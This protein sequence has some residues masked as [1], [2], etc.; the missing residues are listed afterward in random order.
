MMLLSLFWI[1]FLAGSFVPLGSEVFLLALQKDGQ[2]IGWLLFISTL[3]NTLGGMSCY[4]IA[5]FG[6]RPLIHK[7]LRIQANK[8]DRWEGRLSGKGEWIALLCW[9]P[10]VGEVFAAILGLLSKRTTPIAIYMG[11]G[12]LIRYGIFLGIGQSIFDY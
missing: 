10:A 4:W 11:I 8:L 5:R 12:K 9:L 1:S 2:S 7:Y 3:G 6:G